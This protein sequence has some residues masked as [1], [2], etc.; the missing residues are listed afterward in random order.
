MNCGSGVMLDPETPTYFWFVV[1]A[2]VKIKKVS[3]FVNDED[4]ASLTRELD[5]EYITK[6]NTPVVLGQDKNVAFNWVEGDAYIISNNIEFLMYAYAATNG[7]DDDDIPERMLNE[8]GALRPAV[9][10]KDIEFD[11]NDVNEWVT[12]A[13]DAAFMKTVLNAYNA[14]HSIP[15]IG[16]ATDTFE[17]S[18]NV[19]K[20]AATITGLTVK[21]TSMF[22]D[23]QSNKTKNVVN[24]LTFVG[25]TVDATDVTPAPE[26]AFFLA[27][28]V[29]TGKDGIKFTDVT[30]G[31]DCKVLP[32]TLK[33][34]AVV[35]RAFT[36]ALDKPI[37]NKSALKYADEL[38]IM[39]PATGNVVE[40]A[41]FEDVTRNYITVHTYAEGVMLNV[42]DAEEAK[43]LIDI[44][45]KT[46]KSAKWYSVV[47]GYK[48][49]DAT[50]KPA[51][52]ASIDCSYWTGVIATEDNTDDFFT[53]EELAFAV[54]SVATADQTVVLT[55][56][57]DLMGGVTKE[58]GEGK[59]AT[60]TG[61][62]ENW[63]KVLPASATHN[64]TVKGVK[65]TDGRYTI[66][67]AYI[68]PEKATATAATT[69]YVSLFGVNANVEDLIVK[70]VVI[71][72]KNVEDSYVDGLAYHTLTIKNV[73][74]EDIDITAKNSKV[75]TGGVVGFVRGE[76]SETHIENVTFKG[77]VTG[78]K[79]NMRG[80]IA[81]QVTGYGE[82]INSLAFT[83]LTAEL[84]RTDLNSDANYMAAFGQVV[85]N[86]PDEVVAKGENGY[87]LVLNLYDFHAAVF[88][89]INFVA[90]TDMEED[91]IIQ[92]NYEKKGNHEQFTVEAP[93]AE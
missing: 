52:K 22:N 26:K 32:A 6:I 85:V 73:N 58:D 48:A 28:R 39:K 93:E 30:V 64:I 16:N 55:N 54:N 66:S 5:S 90:A 37:T 27:N 14:D 83:G 13:E 8:E 53:A 10:V 76:K 4:E 84:Q 81:G 12:D 35:G 69:K 71:N 25:C 47:S 75:P 49:A 91:V 17:I 74:V 56:D 40:M 1:P 50:A 7:V 33:S 42:E 20:K 86:T 45:V 77:R 63:A 62:G 59:V 51:T 31:E 44:I 70:N 15:T 29:Y 24:N 78:P 9:I 38:S 18:G 65:G 80:S 3:L 36:D 23:G 61:D 72:D 89:D 92:V 60:A 19:N 41:D 34:T 21:G 79:D 67:N 11:G 57:I 82:K 46:D 87:D 43:E 68:V 88:T 2:D